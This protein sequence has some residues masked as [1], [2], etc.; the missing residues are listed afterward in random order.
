MPPLQYE[1]ICNTVICIEIVRL[2]LFKLPYCFAKPFPFVPIF[3]ISRKRSIPGGQKKP[4]EQCTGE[5]KALYPTYFQSQN[6]YNSTYFRYRVEPWDYQ[7]PFIKPYVQ[8]FR[9]R[10]SG[11]LLPSAFS[12]TPCAK[13][14]AMESSRISFMWSSLCWA[15]KSVSA[16]SPQFLQKKQT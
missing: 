15:V 1:M 11:I 2:I 4:P 13:P 3:K 10:L 8:F 5:N 12:D 16:L 7:Y 9:I 6:P 14:T